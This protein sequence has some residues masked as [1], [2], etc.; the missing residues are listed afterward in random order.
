MG[1]NTDQSQYCNDCYHR[2]S[3]LCT[4]I[5]YAMTNAE[6]SNEIVAFCH[7]FNGKLMQMQ[8][9]PT[10]G[11]GTGE[12][13]VDPL[14]SQHSLVLSPSRR[15]LF[16][17][18]AGSN[19]I[20][21]FRVLKSGVLELADVE[22]S[23]GVRP[24]SI[25]VFKNLLYVSNSGNEANHFASNLSGFLIEGG[26]QLTRICNASYPL[27][28]PSA[29]PSSIIFSPDGRKLVVS[30]LNTNR[31]SV[32]SVNKDGTLTG[33][34]VNDS[35]GEGPFGSLFLSSGILLVS[36]SGPNAL[37][38]YTINANGTLKV[39]SASV[40]NGQLATCWVTT[41]RNEKYAY[42]SNAG[43]DGTITIYQID[44]NGAL[45][46][47]DNVIS[48]KTGMGGPLD[49]GVSENGEYFYVLNGNKGS[50]AVF[51]VRRNGGLRLLQDLTAS[52]LPFIGAQGLAVL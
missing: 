42:T 18:N 33:P 32:F 46:V 25:A 31:I 23:A 17:V 12:A 27:S 28:T 43:G 29:Q 50:I 11:H 44:K 48:S 36:E 41:S 35:S 3:I 37:S 7:R 34:A 51:A 19:S 52:K 13:V 20:S 8:A 16:A 49:S 40:E 24:N 2:D 47:V 9:F 30:E 5:V 6:E 45:S 38:S 39:I 15:Y 10:G 1:R 4:S 22:F 21:S 14:V 26:G